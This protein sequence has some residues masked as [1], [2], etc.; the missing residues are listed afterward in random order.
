MT[1]IAGN[2][3]GSVRARLL[4]VSVTAAAALALLSLAAL[5][6]YAW[7]STPG[8]TTLNHPTIALGG[9]S[10]S[11]SAPLRLTA[12]GPSG[13]PAACPAGSV[14]GCI[15]FKVFAGTCSSFSTTTTYFT[16]IEVV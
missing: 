12:D 9:G 11:D 13:S 15:I 8:A 6:A 7:T 5:P 1:R 2:A 3:R 14:Y 16:D 4:R 10:V